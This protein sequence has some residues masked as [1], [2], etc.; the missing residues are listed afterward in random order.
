[1]TKDLKTLSE[2]AVPASPVLV[3]AETIDDFYT[4]DLTTQVNG[5]FL[6]G[7]S[8]RTQFNFRALAVYIN[9]LCKDHNLPSYV[10]QDMGRVMMDYYAVIRLASRTNGV[11]QDAFIGCREY[12]RDM[13]AEGYGTSL[14]LMDSFQEAAFIHRNPGAESVFCNLVEAPLTV[15]SLGGCV[16]VPVP[17]FLEKMMLALGAP[18]VEMVELVPG[19]TLQEGDFLRFAGEKHLQAEP[20]WH[21]HRLSAAP[22]LSIQAHK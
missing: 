16:T 8:L 11:V 9:E 3:E 5:I 10:G 2:D 12:L 15:F 7:S 6:S 4:V 20:L 13:T 17:S 14:L 22:A 19:L 21:E 18:P 1:M